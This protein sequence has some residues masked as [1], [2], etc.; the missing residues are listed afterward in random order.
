MATSLNVKWNDALPPH[1][2]PNFGSLMTHIGPSPSHT[3]QTSSKRFHVMNGSLLL[4]NP[5]AGDKP[6]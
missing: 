1:S 4:L 2:E 6:L 5:K 3:T